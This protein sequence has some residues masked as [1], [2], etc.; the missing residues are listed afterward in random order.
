[1]ACALHN[2]GYVAQ[3]RGAVEHMATCFAESLRLFHEVGATLGSISC[4]AGLAGVAVHQ[5]A[6]LRAAHLFGAAEAL[7][8]AGNMQVWRAHQVEWE[9]NMAHARALLDDATWNAA[10]VGGRTMTLEQAIADALAGSPMPRATYGAD[11][12]TPARTAAGVQLTTREGEVLR[13]LAQGLTDAQIAQ[14]LILSPHTVNAHLK[15]I[16][17]KL[18]VRSRSAATRLAIEQHLV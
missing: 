2:L 14:Q 18:D 11:A 4:V 3:H 7:R 12:L 9:R 17:R 10:W 6:G 15:A 1:M 16:Y 13:L 8:E 5:Q